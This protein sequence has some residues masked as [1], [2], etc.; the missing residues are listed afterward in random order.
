MTQSDTP[1]TLR[2]TSRD[3]REVQLTGTLQNVRA[4]HASWLLTGG[5][6]IIVVQNRLGQLGRV[7]E[8]M[9]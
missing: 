8:L 5:A 1:L 4:A 7:S 9:G 2:G 6:D 3:G